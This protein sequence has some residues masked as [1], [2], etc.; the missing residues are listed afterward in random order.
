MQQVGG[1]KCTKI[2]VIKYD[3]KSQLG[4]LEVDGR[5]IKIDLKYNMR[6]DTALI[7]FRIQSSGRIFG[8]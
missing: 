6:T 1:K 7:W 5:I 3:G 4:D 2:S 8:A